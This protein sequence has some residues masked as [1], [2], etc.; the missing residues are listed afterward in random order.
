MPS[1]EWTRVR[2]RRLRRTICAGAVVCLF[3][4][5]APGFAQ[6][7]DILGSWD[8][9][10]STPQ[11]QNTSAPLVLK[12]DGDKIVGTFSSPQGDQPVEAE[13][14]DQT[15]TIWFS[16]RTESG[17]LSITMKGAAGAGEMKGT[18]DFGDR[19]QGHWSAKRAAAPSAPLQAPDAR[20]DVNG[21][22]VFQVETAAGSGT[23]TMTFTQEGEKLTGHYSGQLG[24][25]PLAGDVKGNAV[26]FSLDVTVE[27]NQLHIAY[28]GTVE[29]DSMKGTVNL[30][31]PGEGTFTAKKKS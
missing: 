19:G 3:G 23:P 7:A 16:V 13:V 30:G 28:S 12:K 26:R 25:A 11:G 31:G 8:V 1:V 18:V 29:K 2:S 24:E 5:G 22:W 14:T 6:D 15:V 10:V 4:A 17:P 20:V 27:A 21:T 9:S